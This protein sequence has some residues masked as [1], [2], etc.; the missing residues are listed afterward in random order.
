MSTL[1]DPAAL[2]ALVPPGAIS[3]ALQ[4][5]EQFLALLSDTSHETGENVLVALPVV[6]P[7]TG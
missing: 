2:G 1:V 4:H 7:L 3:F 6:P 5:R